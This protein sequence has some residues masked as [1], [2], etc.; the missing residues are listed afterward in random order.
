MISHTTNK[1]PINRGENGI[2][3]LFVVIFTCVLLTIITISFIAMMIRDQQRAL[4]DELSR[5]AYDAAMSGVEDGKRVIAACNSSNDAACNA[6][7]AKKCDTVQKANVA[8]SALDSEVLIQSNTTDGGKELDLAYTCVV[9]NHNTPNY[10]GYLSGHDSSAMLALRGDQAFDTITLSWF[11]SDDSNPV[12]LP[13]SIPPASST[14]LPQ[15]STWPTNRPPIMRAQ[16]IEAQAKQED[17]DTHG[18]TVFL[19]PSTVGLVTASF[20]NDDRRATITPLAP[21]QVRCSTTAL[22]GYYCK[23]TLTLPG[24]AS[25]DTRYLRL[26]S[27]YNKA[28]YQVELQN[29]SNPVKFSGVQ[30]SVDVN[31]RANDIFRR[32]DA[33]IE[34]TDSAVP[35]PRATIDITNNL[36]KSFSVT[37]QEGSYSSSCD[38]SQP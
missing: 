35:Y 5:S 15:L 6:I 13:S 27:L 23:A 34:N 25:N 33:R 8:G 22:A 38:P 24:S 30:W 12:S 21:T 14:S 26:T 17:L 1:Q 31:A 32:V 19:Y 9:I 37:D 10:L 4:D 36:C 28:N 11:S 18:A 3:S 2:T 20:T 16:L 7:E 29:N